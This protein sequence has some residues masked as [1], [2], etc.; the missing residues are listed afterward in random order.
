VKRNYGRVN[1]WISYTW[2]KTMRQFDAINNG[3]PFPAR[4]DRTHDVSVVGI[5]DINDKWKVSATWVYYTGNAVTFRSGKY[6]IDGRIVGYYTERNGYRMPDYHRLDL[7][8]TWQRKKT[9]KFESSWNFSV[10]N[11]YA[12]ENAY[13]IDFR[14]NK[15][16]PGTTEALQVALFKAIPSVSYKFKF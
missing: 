10:Y 3:N 12:R 6:E 15:N 14:E 8:V 5:F 9:S 2:S 16:N 1:G 13:Y 7:G 11:A 4:Y